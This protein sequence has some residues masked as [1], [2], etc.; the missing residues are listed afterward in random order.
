MRPVT[1]ALSGLWTQTCRVTANLWTAWSAASLRSLAKNP[2][3]DRVGASYY[4]PPCAQ[5]AWDERFGKPVQRK[6]P[7]VFAGIR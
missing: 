6:V 4:L 5:A 7:A 1:T 3:M 2:G